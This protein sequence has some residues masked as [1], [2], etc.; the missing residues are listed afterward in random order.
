MGLFNAKKV[1]TSDIGSVAKDVFS[2]PITKPTHR[3]IEKIKPAMTKQPTHINKGDGYTH[4][5][6]D[7]C[8]TQPS[9]D[10]EINEILF[11][12]SEPMSGNMLAD[13]QINQAHSAITKMIESAVIEGK[14]EEI[15]NL[16]DYFY[17]KRYKD[18]YIS[19]RI[20]ELKA[21]QKEGKL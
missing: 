11:F 21:N 12:Q 16:H 19:K 9:K 18:N 1:N 10:N 6:G 20:A 3:K 2:K 7:D 15:K 5:D 14:I 13:W 17:D 4:F 8:T